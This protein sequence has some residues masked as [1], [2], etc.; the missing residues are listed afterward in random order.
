MATAKPKPRATASVPT[1]AP[2]VPKAK[3]GY[4]VKQSYNA[5]TTKVYVSTLCSVISC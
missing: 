1:A 4:K 3:S 2:A 5:D